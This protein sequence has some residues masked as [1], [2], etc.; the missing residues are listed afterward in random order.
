MF[1]EVFDDLYS[2]NLDSWIWEKITTRGNPGKRHRHTIAL[3]HST[4]I[5]YGGLLF[6]GRNS[7]DVATNSMVIIDL[8]ADKR[9][10]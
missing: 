3:F 2:L 4:M 9:H 5:V 8:E 10:I 1:F 7:L 6:T